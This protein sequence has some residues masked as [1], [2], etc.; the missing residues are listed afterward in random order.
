MSNT[1][2]LSEIWPFGLTLTRD[3]PIKMHQV[4]GLGSRSVDH[5][6]LAFVLLLP[7]AI[8]RWSCPSTRTWTLLRPSIVFVVRIATYAIRAV[9]ANGNYSEGLFI[10]EQILLLVGLLP[11]VEPIVVL[12]RAHVRRNWTP[13]PPAQAG[14]VQRE[15]GLMT[16]ALRI[17]QAAVLV[18]LILGFVAGAKAGD[19][20]IPCVYKLVTS[21]HN[22][23]MLS[24]GTKAAFYLLSALPEFLALVAYL[25]INLNDWYDLKEAGWK[26]KV[27]KMMKKGEWPEGMAFVGKDE[28]ERGQG[29][30]LS[31]EMQAGAADKV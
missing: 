7:L 15:V 20:L 1:V 22:P 26:Q 3:K 17:L 5:L 23:S 11:L 24:S 9:E 2:A 19:A 31:F 25:S 21:L 16:R 27:K 29:R 10:A 14:E 13:V 6:H 4:P 8:W 30:G 18:A 28:Y 12:L